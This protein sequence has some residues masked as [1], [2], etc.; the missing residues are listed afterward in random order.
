M[1]DGPVTLQ[2]LVKPSSFCENFDHANTYLW[3]DNVTVQLNPG[4][5][6]QTFSTLVDEKL[7]LANRA[8]GDR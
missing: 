7:T 8:T 1:V 3:I 6:E 5:T 4:S 2:F